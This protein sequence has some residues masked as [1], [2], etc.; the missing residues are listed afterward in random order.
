[1]NQT[2][3]R[4]VFGLAGA[5]VVAGFSGCATPSGDMGEKWI[6]PRPLGREFNTFR[7]PLRPGE[8]PANFSVPA[9]QEPAGLLTLTQALAL[10]LAHNP[11]LAT[12]SWEVRIGEA[13]LLQAGLRPNPEA[14]VEVED[15][16]GTGNF[17]GIE[18]AQTTIQLSQLIELGGKRAARME[19]AALSRELA[20]WDYE[21]QRI[22]VFAR[23]AEAFVEV[24]SLQ[25]R[26]ALAEETVGLAEQTVE[27][28]NKRVDAARTFAVEGA[29]ARV[30]LASVE[31]ERDQT[32]RALDAARQRLAANWGSTQPRYAQV[33]GNL[34]ALVEVPPLD[35]LIQ[36]L[37]QN[38]ELAR[39]ATELSRR[40]A[41]LKME[42]SQRIPNITVAGGYRRF[43]GPEENAFITGISVPLPLFE[44]NE[45]NI[46]EAEYRLRQ[47]QDERRAAM[48]RITTALGQSWHRL[49]A[50][51]AEVIAIKEKVLPSAGQT[52]DSMSQYYSEGRISYLEVLDAQRTFF[53]SRDQYAR[54]LGDYHQAVIA[55]ERL[56][57]EP[58][59]AAA[60]R[61]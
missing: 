38:P 57:G 59:G 25:Q 52:F 7:P 12:F 51:Q 20:G 4:Y 3:I 35:H 47:A 19:V 18:E 43:S 41:S 17:Q 50:A 49:V 32:R 55:V 39:W 16:L 28:V 34:E 2:D 8:I 33:E 48:L 24:L 45:G 29:K 53:A 37:Q 40:E 5:A 42:R 11:E 44:K 9:I 10:S 13:R 15:V 14:G 54:A 26:L 21:T 60:G 27:A 30:A 1:M 58:L 56:I 31:I 6:E 36:R 61:P 22:E 46:K 23:T